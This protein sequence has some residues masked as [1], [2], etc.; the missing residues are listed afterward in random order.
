MFDIQETA[1]RLQEVQ[2]QISDLEFLVAQNPQ[3]KGL[4]VNLRSLR[5]LQQEFEAQFQKAAHEGFSD[6]SLSNS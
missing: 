2:K 3:E 5:H 1:S 4:Q 6:V